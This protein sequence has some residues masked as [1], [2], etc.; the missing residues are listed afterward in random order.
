MKHQCRTYCYS[1]SEQEIDIEVLS[2]KL[3]LEL[4]KKDANAVKIGFCD[5]YDV[6]INNMLRKTLKDLFGKEKVLVELKQQYNLEYFLARVPE[7]YS[8]SDEPNQILSLEPDIIKF[9]CE[10]ETID[11]LD[12][13]IY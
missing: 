6:N 7:I 9:L 3:S 5:E 13:Y 4:A 11:D 1:H 12:Y 2:K 10:T 8:E